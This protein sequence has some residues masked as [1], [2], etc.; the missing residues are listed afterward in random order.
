MPREN[1]GQGPSRPKQSDSERRAIRQQYRELLDSIGSNQQELA[2][3]VKKGEADPLIEALNSVDQT[4]ER[5]ETPREGV[6]DAQC[7]KNISQV[8]L[9]RVQKL[10]TNLY[11][12]NLK[13]F[14]KKIYKYF[15]QD[16]TGEVDTD[17]Y[18][19]DA[20]AWERLGCSVQV[21]FKKTPALR[22]MYGS[23]DPGAPVP[24]Q[25]KERKI[26]QKD[27]EPKKAVVPQHLKDFGELK[28]SENTNQEVGLM[29]KRLKH[30]FQEHKQPVRRSDKLTNQPAENRQQVVT[31]MSY[32]K[33]QQIIETFNI[34]GT[35]QPTRTGLNDDDDDEDDMP[36]QPQPKKK[37]K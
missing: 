12:F 15:N 6:L 23:F 21:K 27:E 33:Y 5:V 9:L 3:I 34:K 35:L 37:K 30:K 8:S 29:S 22:Y 17:N 32:E 10:C 4:F 14:G 2:Q 16:R 31:T 11:V 20:D 25:R 19:L 24:K 28:V 13:E 1:E 18:H 26:R 36:P 7:V